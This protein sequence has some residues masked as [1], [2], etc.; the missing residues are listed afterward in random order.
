MRRMASAKTS[1][2]LTTSMRRE[3]RRSGT[4]SV[5]MKREISRGLDAVV[6]GAGEQRVR[7]AGDDVERAGRLERPARRS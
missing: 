6:G 5:T 7:A 4:V 3:V 2:T 1:A